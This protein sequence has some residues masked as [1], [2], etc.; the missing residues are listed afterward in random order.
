MPHA[1]RCCHCSHEWSAPCERHEIFDQTCPSCGVVDVEIPRP[2]ES[3]PIWDKTVVSGNRQFFGEQANS[4][5]EGWHPN[6]VGEVRSL[7]GDRYGACVQKDGSVRFSDRD[8][9]R[10][11]SRALAGLTERV[12]EQAMRERGRQIA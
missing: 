1:L 10:G 8:E 5:T 7:L 12:R 4:L 9:Q 11:Y 3:V 6:E 2:V